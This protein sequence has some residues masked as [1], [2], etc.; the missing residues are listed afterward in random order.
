MQLI[1]KPLPLPPYH[2]RVRRASTPT[3]FLA[4]GA[5]L[6]LLIFLFVGMLPSLLLGGSAAAQVAMETGATAS[7]GHG[8]NVLLVLG[9][10]LGTGVGALLFAALGA[11]AGSAVGALTWVRSSRRAAR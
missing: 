11:A 4:V 5:T 7:H 1:S 2:P 3:S 9:V 6:G 10:L 8:Y